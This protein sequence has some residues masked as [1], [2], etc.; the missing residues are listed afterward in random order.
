VEAVVSPDDLTTIRG[1]G[2]VMLQRLNQAGIYTY[3]QLATSTPDEL[4]QALREAARLA[5]VEE[6]IEQA[7]KLAGLA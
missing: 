5:K 6:W 4:R 3:A 7:Q 2:P 1:I